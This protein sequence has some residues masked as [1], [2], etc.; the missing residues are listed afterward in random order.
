MRGS[1]VEAIGNCLI[2]LGNRGESALQRSQET[3]HDLERL[4]RIP[5]V[6]DGA[7]AVAVFADS[8]RNLPVVPWIA[9]GQVSA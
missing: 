3:C 5:Q 6:F 8:D 7:R 9:E 4:R 1:L 2:D